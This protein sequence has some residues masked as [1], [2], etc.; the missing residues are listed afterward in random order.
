M[1]SPNS[2]RE[3]LA[4]GGTVIGAR[5]KTGSPMFIEV[6]GD[7]GMDFVWLDFEHGGPS[8]EDST[9][10]EHYTRA[11]ETSDVEL[12]VRLP[13]GEPSLIRKVLDAGIRTVLIPRVETAEEVREAAKATRF[14]YDGS[15]GERGFAAG[16][17]NRWGAD[18]DGYVRRADES[19]LMG[20]QI[21]HRHAVENLDEILSVPELGF[22][23]IGY[24]DLSISLGH[25]LDLD[26]PTVKGT[27]ADVRDRCQEANVP[28]GFT[29]DTT[30][31]AVSALEDGFELVRVGDEVSSVRDAI[32]GRMER[33]RG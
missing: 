21:E 18:L 25:P 16:R 12:L 2:V 1:S 31:D 27:I 15:P 22:V 5:C 24:G 6:Y 30:E 17:A 7:L 14:V 28:V 4:S 11:A 26:H 32:G 9:V 19:V 8:P 10:F 20:V 13:S 3:T 23:F 29:V 33:L